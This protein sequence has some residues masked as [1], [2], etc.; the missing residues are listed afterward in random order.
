M[1]KKSFPAVMSSLDEMVELVA[2]ECEKVGFEK[3]NLHHIQLACEEVIVNI[4]SYAYPDET[5]DIRISIDLPDER[6][7]ISIYI[8]D[9]G[10]PFNP[11]EKKDPDVSAS[12]SEREI[13]GLGIF[14][15]K[16]VMDTV[17]YLRKDE[18]NIVHLEKFLP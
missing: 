12:A 18:S 4:I 15:V 5:G 13:G 14:L 7:G 6:P 10:I 8:K 9:S 11:L 2:G 17:D 3:K 1:V 16:K